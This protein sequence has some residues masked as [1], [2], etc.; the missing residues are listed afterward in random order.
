MFT[1]INAILGILFVIVAIT[2]SFKN[3]LFALILVANS[4]I[5][6]FQEIRAKKTLDALAI[7]GQ[8]QP[9]VRRSGSPP[10]STPTR[11]CSTTSSRSVRAIRSSSTRRGGDRRGA[12]R[13]RIAADR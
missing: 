11:W 3:G 8:T 1:R 10:R 7:V 5:G 13:R 9:V 12:G 4:G 6:I 2:G